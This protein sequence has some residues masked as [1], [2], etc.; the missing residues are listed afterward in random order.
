MS[1]L[2]SMDQDKVEQQQQLR[3]P[4]AA[5]ESCASSHTAKFGQRM[6]FVLRL[7]DARSCT[8][9]TVQ[10]EFAASETFYLNRLRHGN[11]YQVSVSS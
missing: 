9:V 7:G 2:V 1:S 5:N 10:D 6:E 3:L 4:A 8:L 11:L